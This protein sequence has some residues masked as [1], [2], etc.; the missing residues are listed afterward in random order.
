MG[1]ERLKGGKGKRK[2]YLKLNLGLL[3]TWNT[4]CQQLENAYELS[5]RILSMIIKDGKLC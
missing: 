3:R 1:F 4:V 2:Q 5:E